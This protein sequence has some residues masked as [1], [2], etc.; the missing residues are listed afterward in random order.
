M[1]KKKPAVAIEMG[2][3]CGYSAVRVGRLLPPGG[4][5]Y[6]FEID[7]KFAANARLVVEHAGLSGK[8][9]V[10]D[11]SVA[12]GLKTLPTLYGV[13]CVDLVFIDHVRAPP[14]D[15]RLFACALRLSSLSDAFHFL[16]APQSKTRYLPDLQLLEASGLLVP[17][18]VLVADNVIYPG[19]PDYLAYVR[20]SPHYV[21]TCHRAHLEYRPEIEDAVEVSVFR[22]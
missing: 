11:K 21:S 12:D 18:S 14:L 15:L 3:Y 8:V 20:S 9:V 16:V 10:I 13:R 1:K 6:S 5:L 4:R 7:S 22:S 17:G 19:A 2:A